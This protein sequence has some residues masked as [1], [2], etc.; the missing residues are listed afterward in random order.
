M[1]FLLFFVH[2]FSTVD[3]GEDTTDPPT[4]DEND[5][6]PIIAN[7]PPDMEVPI[8]SD[9]P[10]VVAIWSEPTASDAS[11]AAV[12]LQDKNYDA[13]RRYMGAGETAKVRYVFEDRQRNSA[14]CEFAITGVEGMTT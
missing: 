8:P 10:F 13:P 14:T 3:G 7:C 11:G 9:L 12:P 1:L 5:I 2:L 6:F 4:R